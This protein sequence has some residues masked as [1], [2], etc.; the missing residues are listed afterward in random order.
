MDQQNAPTIKKD[1][2]FWREVWQQVRLVFRLIRDPEVPFYLKIV[3]FATM[4]YL[5][6][7]VDL[8][9][10]VAPVLGQIDDVAFL[11]A[12]SK[13]FLELAPAHVVAR[14]MREIREQDGYG[15]GESASVA[16]PDALEDAIIIDSEHEV[17]WQAP[18]VSQK[19]G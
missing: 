16:K 15:V 2:G 11:L 10:D 6:I 12:G 8:L 17:I 3:P 14:H 5:L 9:P 1:P 18:D 7:P 13:I 19:A 4:V